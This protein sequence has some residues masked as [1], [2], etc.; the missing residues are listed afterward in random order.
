M[1]LARKEFC[2]NKCYTG[3]LGSGATISRYFVQR[4]SSSQ[5]GN[6]DQQLI[7]MMKAQD[8]ENYNEYT[9][10]QIQKSSGQANYL[11]KPLHIYL[12]KH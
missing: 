9:S 5:F 3:I 10:S 7:N 4:L 6:P 11:Y 1:S 2:F 8:N 12:S